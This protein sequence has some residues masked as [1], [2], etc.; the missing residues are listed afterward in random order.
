VRKGRSPGL[1]AAG[2]R[3]EDSMTDHIAAPGPMPRRRRI[4][5]FWFWLIEGLILTIAGIVLG[6]CFD[7]YQTASTL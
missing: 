3:L 6:N 1:E 5:V 7:A 2:H 4:V